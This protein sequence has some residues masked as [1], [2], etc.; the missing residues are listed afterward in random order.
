M[1]QPLNRSQDL[2]DL[3]RLGL[4]FGVLNIDSRV[5]LPWGLVDPMAGTLLPGFSEVVIADA[6]DIREADTFRVQPHLSDYAINPQHGGI[7]SLLVSLSRADDRNQRIRA[8]PR[9]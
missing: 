1:L 2:L 8:R 3:V 9:A 5:T 6:A 7:V 4:A